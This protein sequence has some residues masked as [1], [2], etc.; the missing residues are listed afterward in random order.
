MNF[1]SRQKLRSGSRRTTAR[2]ASAPAEVE[3]LEVRQ[4]LTTTPNL[5]TPTGT[6]TDPTPEFTW[7]SVDNAES[8]DL[9]ITSLET[10]E[11]SLVVRGITD[12]R[13]EAAQG[14]ISQ[15]N[16]RVW[17][18]ANLAGGGT[19]SWSPAA[20]IRNQAAPTLLGPIGV[21]SNNLVAD[22]TPEITWASGTKAQRFQIW[23]SDLTAKAR[24][25][26]D[27]AAAGSTD[28][29]SVSEYATVYTLQNR[30]PL[31]DQNGDPVLDQFGDQRLEEVRSIVLPQD[32]DGLIIP[33]AITFDPSA[34]IDLSN[35]QIT[36]QAHG[37]NTGDLV[38]YNHGG[39]SE[40]GGLADDQRYYSIRI[41]NDTIQLAA[42]ATDALQQTPLDLTSNG[43]G[44]LHRLTDVVDERELGTGRYRIWMRTIDQSGRTTSWSSALTFDVGPAPENLSPAN[45]SIFR[46]P[47]LEWDSVARATHYEVTVNR[48]GEPGSPIFR[49]TVAADPIAE[50]QSTFIIQSQAGTPIV[51]VA[52][53]DGEVLASERAAMDADG[54][55]VKYPLAWGEYTFWVRAINQGESGEGIP[56]VTGAWASSDFATVR[57]GNQEVLAPD[58]TA[59]VPDQG[60]VTSARP[61]IEW[62]TVHGAARYEVLVHKFNSR[63]PFLEANSTSTSYTFTE[64]LPSGDY[65]VWVRALDPRGNASPWSDPYYFTASG[66]RPVVTSPS[67]GEAVL[68]PTFTWIGIPEA[69]SYE[70]WVSYD[71]VD[72][73]FVNVD[74]I[75]GTS[76]RPNDPSDPNS[77]PFEDGD[78]RIWVRALYTDGTYSPWSVPVSF[79][80]GTAMNDGDRDDRLV[81][82]ASVDGQAGEP[83]SAAVQ[84]QNVAEPVPQAEHVAAPAGATDPGIAPVDVAQAQ[85]IVG[86]SDS[87]AEL[88]EDLVTKIAERCVESEWW[89]E[90]V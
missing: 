62:S 67:A 44:T 78:Y 51:D 60:F 17:V 70:V 41:D 30:V 87:G 69:V 72:F 53:T 61:T 29:I 79:R 77:Q 23:L 22:S 35:D 43:T 48:R 20:T 8:Y 12:T 50:R 7:E 66:G 58:V 68:F 5:L 85:P 81:M 89:E 32:A 39:G 18:R 47:K 28:P 82:L 34:A 59:P 21:G 76:F 10:Y 9:W 45:P 86:A 1:L 49:R 38:E 83:T 6:F 13:Y 80:G 11:T 36:W 33:R 73:T 88:P 14:E 15:G 16:L 25:E 64:N 24:A 52:S 27:T 75:T 54:N 2:S 19:S 63:P 31:V 46:S 57:D 84:S 74:G 40:V 42:S 4:L 26:A 90:T 3:L 65:T 71:G 56:R 37:L 55:E